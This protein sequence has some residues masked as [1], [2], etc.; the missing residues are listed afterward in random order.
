MQCL[1]QIFRLHRFEEDESYAIWATL[2]FPRDGKVVHP[3]NSGE[4]CD[5]PSISG[6]FP[7]TFSANKHPQ[8]GL[9]IVA[10]A[11]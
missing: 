8:R 9:K 10:V 2:R 5:E 7:T 1:L 3:L 6:L 4:D 11:R